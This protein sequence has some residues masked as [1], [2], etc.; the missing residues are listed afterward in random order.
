[1]KLRG[2]VRERLIRS[3]ALALAADLIGKTGTLVLTLVAARMLSVAE[4]ARFA[5]CLALIAVLTAVI[6]AGAQ[7]LLTRDAA[8]AP[9]TRRGLLIAL[10]KGRLPLAFV[11]LVVAVPLGRLTLGEPATLASVGIALI[12][13]VALSLSG[14]CRSNEQLL[15]ETHAR[16]ALALLQLIAIAAAWVLRADSDGLL[17]LLL[18]ANTIALAPFLRPVRRLLT[19]TTSEKASSAVRRAAPFGLMALTTIIFYRAGTLVLGAFSTARETAVFSVASNLG[20]GLLA[21]PN[22]IT[23]GLLPRL[24]A[25]HAATEQATTVRRAVI[26]TFALTVPAALATALL[27]PILLPLV[28]GPLY[29]AAAAPL[30]VLVLSVLFIA[31][32][33]IAGTLLIVRGRTRV[34]G[35][36]VAVS[37]VVNLL[38]LVVLIHAGFGALGAALATLLCEAVGVALLVPAAMRALPELRHV[39]QRPGP[40]RRG[41][42]QRGPAGATTS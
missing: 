12:A 10:L 7:T 22:A 41:R 13:G 30:A 28:L 40:G 18:V 21:L 6:D 24:S 36:Q 16:L 32:S 19:G 14:L 15:P 39:V 38:A 9:E 29:G 42:T 37:F 26:W 5:V 20:F 35:R 11:I 25:T 2:I 1:M 23:T 27:G 31:V 34:L 8:A 4:F 17:V 3:S 33:G